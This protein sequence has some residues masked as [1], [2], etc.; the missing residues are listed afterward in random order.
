MARQPGPWQR[1]HRRTGRPM[2]WYAWVGGKLK[3]LCDPG[4]TK[5]EAWDVL[6]KLQ[7]EPADAAP[8]PGDTPAA[9]SPD[10]TVLSLCDE[11]VHHIR[12]TLPKE[13]QDFHVRYVIAFAREFQDLPFRDLR[14]FHL[15]RFLH[16][17]GGK[18]APKTQAHAVGCISTALNWCL[19]QGFIAANP[20]AGYKKPK[21]AARRRRTLTPD[22]ES[23]IAEAVIP[24]F[25][26][27]LAVMRLTGMRPGEVAKLTARDCDF[28]TRRIVL[29]Q[30]KT[31]SSTGEVRMD[32]W[33][34]F[35]PGPARRA[36]DG[37]ARGRAGLRDPGADA[38]RVVRFGVG[39]DDRLPGLR[40]RSRGTAETAPHRGPRARV[41][42]ETPHAR[43]ASRS[44]PAL[45]GVELS[46]TAPTRPGV[47]VRGTDV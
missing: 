38:L 32:D 39:F 16:Q 25:R 2:G 17:H 28:A 3:R 35:G 31:A 47:P 15:T 30:H 37:A 8:P 6:R 42:V 34:G 5:T 7:V 9:E 46:R 4:C 33:V 18:W 22:Q 43:T 29:E 44:G 10:A 20:L 36:S 19:D 45:R 27:F 14:K 23:R 40:G 21:K 1:T 13:R 24:E 41:G 11:F 12:T 26:E